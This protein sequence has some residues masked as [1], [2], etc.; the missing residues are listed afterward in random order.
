MGLLEE[1]CPWGMGFRVSNAEAK[2]SASLFCH[3]L[4]PGVELWVPPG[5][6]CLPDYHHDDNRLNL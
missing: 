5:A 1:M 4:I 3:L 6:P 2:P